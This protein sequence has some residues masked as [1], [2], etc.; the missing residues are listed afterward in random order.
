[1]SSSAPPRRLRAHSRKHRL[2]DRH[3]VQVV[4]GAPL[5]LGLEV[6]PL[7]LRGLGVTV[8][9]QEARLIL[10]RAHGVAVMAAI[11]ADDGAEE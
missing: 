11:A 6:G 4:V 1:M 2:A 5:R 9:P 8:L 3:E 10:E 7:L